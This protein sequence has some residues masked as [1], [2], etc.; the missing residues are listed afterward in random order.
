VVVGLVGVLPDPAGDPVGVGS[1]VSLDARRGI[2]DGRGDQSPDLR[3]EGLAF[4]PET[5]GG[6]TDNFSDKSPPHHS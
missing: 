4:G 6:F 3:A 1:G 5:D 2:L